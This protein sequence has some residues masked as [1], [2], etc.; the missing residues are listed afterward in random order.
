MANRL[1]YA[2]D[3]LASL[4]WYVDVLELLAEAVQ[5]EPPALRLPGSDTL[6]FSEQARPGAH[7]L[8]VA[9]VAAAR[10]Q[11]KYHPLVPGENKGRI[12]AAG[13]GHLSL[14]DPANNQLT[15]LERGNG[16]LLPEFMVW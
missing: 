10:Q 13:P 6:V 2:P 1:I 7:V 14:I 9:S 8:P 16:E 3:L 15:L 4:R 5:A 12:V 11:F